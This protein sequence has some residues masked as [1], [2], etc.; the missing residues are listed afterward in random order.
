MAEANV[1][2]LRGTVHVTA[3]ESIAVNLLV[4]DHTTAGQVS[5]CPANGCPMGVNYAATI[6]SAAQGDV[7]LL[8]VGDTVYSLAS[9]AITVGDYVAA[10]ASGKVISESS[11]KSANTIGVALSTGTDV[12][13]YWRVTR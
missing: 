11:T 7:Q 3:S 10:A 8:C 6:A 13:V 5:L 9:G 1:S 2:H 12:N 4:E